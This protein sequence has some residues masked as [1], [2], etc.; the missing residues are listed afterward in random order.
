MEKVIGTLFLVAALGMCVFQAFQAIKADYIWDRDYNSYWELA[1]KSSTIV[2]KAEH[3][4][5][6][7]AEIEKNKEKF[8]EYNAVFMTTPDNSFK[9][10]FEALKTLN[11]RLNE[12][13]GMDVKSFEFQTALQQITDQEMSA[14]NAGPTI[15]VIKQCY[16]RGTCN[17]IWQAWAILY[18][19][20]YFVLGAIGVACL[21]A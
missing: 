9:G 12:I 14:E 19:I 13:R 2:P 20:G 1:D 6:F 15:T 3:V 5:K 10:N 17:I 18:C 11:V 21:K 7:V 4:A 8:A 16:R